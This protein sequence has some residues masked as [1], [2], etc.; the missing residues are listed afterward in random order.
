MEQPTF[1]K[2]MKAYEAM[3]RKRKYNAEYMAKYRKEHRD[4]W[5]QK[6]RERYALKQSYKK[7]PIE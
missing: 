5:N 7:K 6:Q 3:E 4:E 1:E 2:L